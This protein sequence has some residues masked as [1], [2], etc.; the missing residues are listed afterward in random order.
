M[1]GYNYGT[2]RP[3]LFTEEGQVLL[4]DVRDRVQE[5]LAAAG[6]FR[7]THVK[8]KAGAYD[9]F[10]LMACIDRLVELKEIELIPRSCWKQFEVYASPERRV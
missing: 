7:F 8:P 9:S 10:Q 1:S 2:E 3:K 4:L 5:L 6:A